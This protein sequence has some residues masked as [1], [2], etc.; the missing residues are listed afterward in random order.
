MSHSYDNKDG[1]K[2]SKARKH[3]ES[4][5]TSSEPLEG[6]YVDPT[7][8][9]HWCP[10]RQYWQPLLSCLR[11]ARFPCPAI[12]ED[13]QQLLAQSPFVMIDPVGSTLIQKRRRV[14]MY[15]LKYNDGRLV[16]AGEDF[17]PENLDWKMME[18]VA[19]VLFVSKIFV[20]QIR[21]VAK[22]AEE[23]AR[24]RK[25]LSRSGAVPEEAEDMLPDT[26]TDEL[27][28]DGMLPEVGSSRGRRRR[29]A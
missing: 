20:P 3:A 29:T 15:I 8:K 24:I 18:D 5:S 11:C 6:I 16:D 25:N 13:K 22:P 9:P 21:L 4:S 27:A 7:E 17:D 19:E 1:K 28:D 2:R 23:R 26:D 12:G 10:K 14:A